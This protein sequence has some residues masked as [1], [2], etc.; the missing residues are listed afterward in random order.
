MVWYG[1]VWYHRLHDRVGGSREHAI[2]D[3]VE[4]VAHGVDL[5]SKLCRIG[6]P[7]VAPPVDRHESGLDTVYSMILLVTSAT[8]INYNCKVILIE[9]E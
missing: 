4:H 7:S 9:S 3:V 5:Q 6:W 8:R 2:C 1:L